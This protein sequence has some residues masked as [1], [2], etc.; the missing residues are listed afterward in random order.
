MC[1]VEFFCPVSLTRFYSKTCNEVK[2]LWLLLI[3]QK[4]KSI[5]PNFRSNFYA[6]FPSAE[7]SIFLKCKYE[8]SEIKTFNFLI[9]CNIFNNKT[10]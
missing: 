6:Y 9:I 7:N 10:V 1:C 2:F 8:I 3:N 4:L 5:S